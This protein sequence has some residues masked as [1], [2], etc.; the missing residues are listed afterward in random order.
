VLDE[1][2][3]A[4]VASE[5][6]IS[7]AFLAT[8]LEWEKIQDVSKIIGIAT[9]ILDSFL[10]KYEGETKAIG[11]TG[12]MHGILYVDGQGAAVSP[13]YTWQD[14]RG[15]QPYKDTTYAA[16]LGSFAGY[17]NVTDF[18]NRQNGLRPMEAVNYCTVQ[19]YRGMVLCEN[20]TPILHASNAASL[21]LYDVEKRTFA[22][23]YH[24]QVT[25]AFEVIGTYRNIPVAVAIGDNQASVFSTL[26]NEADLLINVGTGSQI[27]IV[28]DRPLQKENVECRPY[29]NGKYLIVGAALCGGRAYSLLK[30]FY[31]ALLTAAGCCDTDVYGMMTQM[32]ENKTETTLCVDPR[33]AGTRSDASVRGS[34]RNLS[35]ENFTPADLTLGVLRGMMEELYGMYR[36]MGETRCGI[37]GSGNGIRKNKR[38]QRV[39]QEVFGVPLVIPLYQEEAA[40]GAALFALVACSEDKDVSQ[41]QRLIQYAKEV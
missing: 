18:Y 31:T 28:S 13:L 21:G 14:E 30:D 34:I 40:C 32:I 20:S 25:D 24:A 12:Q 39:A 38:L 8:E 35:E 4:V 6:V 23:D 16:Y 26:A 1:K 5:T 11:L 17:G 37:V 3:G 7:D 36:S 41:V 19:D 15:N 29:V 9:S 22:Y 2:S 27:S 10:E 33:F